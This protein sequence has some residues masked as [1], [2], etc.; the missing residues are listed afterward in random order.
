SKSSSFTTLLRFDQFAEFF[1]TAE[2]QLTDCVGRTAQVLADAIHRQSFKMTQSDHKA[3]NGRQPVNGCEKLCGRFPLLEH[4][5]RGRDGIH[6][7]EAVAPA[8]AVAAQRN[9]PQR[10]PFSRSQMTATRVGDVV[11]QTLSEPALEFRLA[12]AAESM[13]G[14]ERV[15]KSLL[16]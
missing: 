7:S 11:K 8:V 10:A 16:D 3:I 15:G 9:L 5:T 12:G 14:M 4:G 2:P 1:Q 6:D 13:D